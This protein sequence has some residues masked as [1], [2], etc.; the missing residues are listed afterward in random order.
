[1]EGKDNWID[2]SFLSK[3]LSHVINTTFLGVGE[4]LPANGK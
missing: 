2:A 1:M 3:K 4:H